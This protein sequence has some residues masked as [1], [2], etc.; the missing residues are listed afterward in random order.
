MLVQALQEAHK[1]GKNVLG[2]HIMGNWGI[3]ETSK[4]VYILNDDGVGNDKPLAEDNPTTIPVYAELVG[5]K[6]N[7]IR[8][9]L[10]PTLN[11]TIKPSNLHEVPRGEQENLQRF[12]RTFGNRLDVNYEIWQK[13]M[14]P[15]FEEETSE[16]PA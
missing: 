9:E 15:I 16:V 12:I 14:E 6:P 7:T 2:S 10:I 11:L 3:I 4:G 13:A 1:E 5:D 8:S